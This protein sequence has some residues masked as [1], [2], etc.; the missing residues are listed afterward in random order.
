MK[1]LFSI[2]ISACFFT[3]FSVSLLQAKINVTF[4]GIIS[5]EEPL[6]K[7][8]LERQIFRELRKFPKYSIK[9]QESI[10]LLYKRGIIN[11]PDICS[12]TVIKLAKKIRSRIIAYGILK[13]MDMEYKRNWLFPWKGNLKFKHS[14]WLKIIDG[15]N[16][17]VRYSGL[18]KVSHNVNNTYLGWEPRLGKLDPIFRHQ[19]LSRIISE[20]A[21]N[22]SS[23]LCASMKGLQKKKPKKKLYDP[24]LFKPKQ[25]IKQKKGI[26]LKT[27]KSVKAPALKK[28]YD[29]SIFLKKKKKTK[30]KKQDELKERLLKEEELNELINN[31]E[32]SDDVN[33]LEDM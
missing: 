14:M 27:L 23:M 16:G 33:L 26:E 3:G 24:S 9:T 32:I 21:Q 30:E 17:E 6:M 10:K 7:K 5:G 15:S 18:L 31:E 19:Q 2:L 22:T 4:L 1:S 28:K 8:E 13:K 11:S 12:K 20:L 29:A 25:E